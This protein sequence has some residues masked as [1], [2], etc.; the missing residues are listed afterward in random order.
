MKKEQKLQ[1]RDKMSQSSKDLKFLNQKEN[2]NFTEVRT[3]AVR[4]DSKWGY[5]TFIFN[6]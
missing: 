5:S 4:K 6:T 1:T 2:K 3:D